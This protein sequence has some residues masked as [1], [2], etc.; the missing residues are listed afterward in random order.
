MT[1]R[2]SLHLLVDELSDD[3]VEKLARILQELFEIPARAR[4]A[5][6]QEPSSVAARKYPALAAAWDNDDDAIFDS[7]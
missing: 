4:G 7:L 6:G 5:S 2:E 3:Q 1:T